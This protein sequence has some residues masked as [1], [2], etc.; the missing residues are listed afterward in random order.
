MKRLVAVLVLTLG[1]CLGA[2]S[3]SDSGGSGASSESANPD[4]LQSG[5]PAISPA[6]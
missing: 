3:P 4:Q 6:S 5:A 2:C 1:L